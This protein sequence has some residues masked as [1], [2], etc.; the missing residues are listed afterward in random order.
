VPPKT[1]VEQLYGE[2]W[3]DDSP[4]F[5][6]ELAQSLQ[7][8]GTDWLFELFTELGP[9]PGQLLVDVG[10]RDA[11]HAIRLVREHGLRAIAL[12]PVPHHV[13]VARKAVAEAGVD[14]EVVEAGI[15]AMPIDDAAADWIWCRDVLVH[16]DLARGFA[17]CAR[18]L[19]PGGQMLAYVTCTTDL[20]EPREAAALFEAVAVVPESTEP[21]AIEQHAAAEGLTLVSST[22]LGG[23]WRERMIEDG[24]WNPT[25]DLLQLSRLHRRER[26]LVDRYGETRVAAFTA[27][28]TWGVYQ[29]LGKLRPTV[30][31]WRRDA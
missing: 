3:A 4:A 18:I 7:P 6:A 15:E 20:L 30:Y 27:D 17:E 9:Q 23:E 16:V 2:I 28:R 29:L 26:E 10:A 21:A 1:S 14:V 11:V 22:P 8:R 31:L 25:E 13:E 12:D 24:S 19:R 5:A